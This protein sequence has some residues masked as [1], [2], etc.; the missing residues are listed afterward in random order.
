MYFLKM[1]LGKSPLLTKGSFTKFLGGSAL[2]DKVENK[3]P[4][5]VHPVGIIFS[6]VS[7]MMFLVFKW[8][9]SRKIQRD[10]SLDNL[11]KLR[12]ILLSGLRIVISITIKEAFKHLT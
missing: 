9:Q 7:Q 2:F 6:F 1:F 5:L 12:D 4:S 10:N 11:K 3:S 8:W